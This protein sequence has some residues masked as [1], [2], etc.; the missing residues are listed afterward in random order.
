MTTDLEADAEYQILKMREEAFIL[1]LS[2]GH[3]ALYRMGVR[4]IAESW[5]PD[6]WP[7]WPECTLEILARTGDRS[8]KRGYK[9]TR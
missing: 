1:N 5:G 9:E 6:V 7:S 2:E 8:G 3:Q 4:P